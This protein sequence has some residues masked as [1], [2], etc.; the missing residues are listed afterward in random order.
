MR[1]LVFQFPTGSTETLGVSV[2]K[3]RGIF[4]QAHW[5]WIGVG[6]LIGYMFLFNF[7]N[8]LALTYLKR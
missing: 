7:L 8:I 2:L 5:Y 1:I 6:V 4:P 3:S